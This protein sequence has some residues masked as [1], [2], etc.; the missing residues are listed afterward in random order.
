MGKAK[1]INWTVRILVIFWT[2]LI[3]GIGAIYFLFSLIA[4]GKLG[5][6]PP[7]EELQNPK[8]KFASEIYSSDMIVLGRYYYSRDNRV[9]VP[10]NE[11]SPNLINALIATEDARYHQHSGID[12]KALFRAVSKTLILRQKNAGCLF[13]FPPLPIFS[14]SCL[15]SV[16]S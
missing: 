9:Y 2:L 8:N 12:A 15:Q 1:K 4:N 16:G 11:I 3:L 7:V 13:Y 10:Y 14:V 5:Y 6:L